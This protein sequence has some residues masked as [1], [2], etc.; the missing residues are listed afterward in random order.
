MTESGVDHAPARP[1]GYLCTRRAL[2]IADGGAFALALAGAL[3]LALAGAL[4]CAGCDDKK[5]S[6]E[7]PLPDASASPDKYATADPKLA[8][9]LQATTSRSGASDKGPPADGIFAPGAADARH[10]VGAPTTVDLVSE[11]SEPRVDL[12]PSADASAD[13]A[14]TASYGPAILELGMQMGPR[15]AMPTIDFGLLLGPAKKDDGGTDWLVA[16]VRRAAPSKKQLGDLP[17]GVDKEIGS[18]AGT[19]IRIKMTPDGRESDVRTQ[20]GKGGLSDLE[21]VATSAAEALVFATVPLPGK[22]VGV[23]AQWIAETRMP[24]SGL[25]VI[26]YRAYRVREID[27][28]HL[29]LALDV[30]AY[31][32]GKDVQLQGVPKGATL[33]QF[34]AQLSGDLQVSRGES[35]ARKAQFQQR[36]VMMFEAPGA[37][38][39]PQA[40]GQPPAG[41]LSAQIQSQAVLVRG[42]ELRAATKQP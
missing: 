19:S 36:V 22:P 17:P 23:G 42:D 13:A 2:A 29:R 40:A 10:S 30:K 21:R 27:G 9:A 18:L 12:L 38:Q 14:T 16:E 28:D 4:A 41:M 24:L 31:A 34:D 25:D 32:A 39:A 33:E 37:A 35:L 20:L 5:T 8:K 1:R 6:S 11:G 26:A 15:A 3:A 7:S